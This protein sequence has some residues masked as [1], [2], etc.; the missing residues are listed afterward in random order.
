MT[1]SRPVPEYGEYASPE[2]QAAAMGVVPDPVIAPP[3]TVA[4]VA[5]P[6]L[7]PRRWDLVIS[8]A[9]IAIGAYATLSSIGQYADLAGL[10]NS[11]HGVYGYDGSYPDPA[12]ANGIGLGLNIIQPVALVLVIWLTMRRLRSGRIAFWIPLVVGAI[13][14][15][16]LVIGFAIVLTQDPGFLAYFEGIITGTTPLPTPTP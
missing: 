13:V 10:L 1:D 14:S 6:V 16:L 9:L 12:L 3:P 4:A 5:P 15:V 7:A 2:Q 8:L 11:V